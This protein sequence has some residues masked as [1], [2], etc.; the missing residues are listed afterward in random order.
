VLAIVTPLV[1]LAYLALIDFANLYPWNDTASVPKRERIRDA[2]L[3]YP[4]LVIASIAFLLDNQVLRIIG[5]VL[6]VVY[7]IG[8][9][10]SWWIPYVV[11]A[12]ANQRRQYQTSFSR[13]SKSLPPIRDHPVPDNEHVVVSVLIWVML[14][15]SIVTFITRP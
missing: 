3:N 4:P 1:L 14:V 2:L 11:G 7:T 6:V 12:T 5:L 15:S 10:A 13:T 9:A 8:N